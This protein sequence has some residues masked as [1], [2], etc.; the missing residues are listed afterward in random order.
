M[1]HAGRDAVIAILKILESVLYVMTGFTFIQPKISVRGAVR[2]ANSVMT[3]E[4]VSGKE[5][6]G[7]FLLMEAMKFANVKASA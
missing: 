1:F 3:M 5:E 7:F 6:V 2:D 4:T